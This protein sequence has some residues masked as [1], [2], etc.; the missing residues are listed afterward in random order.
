VTFQHFSSFFDDYC[1]KLGLLYNSGVLRAG[2]CGHCDY[3]VL[4]D[5]LGDVRHLSGRFTGQCGVV[6]VDLVIVND[7]ELNGLVLYVVVHFNSSG[8]VDVK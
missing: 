5:Q 7:Y 1:A 8:F 6:V 4:T 3:L 2:C